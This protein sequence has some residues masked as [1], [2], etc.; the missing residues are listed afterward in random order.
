MIDKE[1]IFMWKC[2]IWKLLSLWRILKSSSYNFSLDITHIFSPWWPRTYTDPGSINF[3]F[4]FPY[5]TNKQSLKQ[6]RKITAYFLF[7]QFSLLTKSN[8]CMQ[9]GAYFGFC[10]V[11][12][13]RSISTPSLHLLDGMLVHR[14]FSI[15][16]PVPNYTSG[17][18]EALW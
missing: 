8:V 9:A 3:V 17:W 18:G 1:H 14:K 4:L 15:R 6:N 13:T 5:R 11:K 12:A 16:L 7:V 10:L 2:Y